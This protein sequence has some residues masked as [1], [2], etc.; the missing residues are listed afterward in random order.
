MPK[1]HPRLIEVIVSVFLAPAGTS[2]L[3][4]TVYEAS[5]KSLPTSDRRSSVTDS[6]KV[7]LSPLSILSVSPKLLVSLKFHL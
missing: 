1:V 3:L 4:R 6:L 2:L 5:R 7:L